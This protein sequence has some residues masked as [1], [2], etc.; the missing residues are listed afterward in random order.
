MQATGFQEEKT[1]RRKASTKL[2]NN[3]PE[4]EYMSQLSDRAL[5]KWTKIDQRTLL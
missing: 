3:T 4:L 2:P 1:E 5:E